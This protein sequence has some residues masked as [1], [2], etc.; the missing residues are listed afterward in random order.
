MMAA[1]R[2]PLPPPSGWEC[3]ECCWFLTPSQF[4]A[5]CLHGLHCPGCGRSASAFRPVRP[6][7]IRLERPDPPRPHA[8]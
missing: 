4:A 8:G 3:G 1:H 7:W 6:R 5:T 2:P